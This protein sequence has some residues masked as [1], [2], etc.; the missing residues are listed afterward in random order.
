MCTAFLASLTNELLLKS[1]KLTKLIEGKP[2][3]RAK[4]LDIVP[5]NVLPAPLIDLRKSSV[6]F[7]MKMAALLHEFQHL[8]SNLQTVLRSNAAAGDLLKN[9]LSTLQTTFKTIATELPVLQD[10]Y[11]RLFINYQRFLNIKVEQPHPVLQPVEQEKPNKTYSGDTVQQQSDEFFAVDGFSDSDMSG[12]NDDEDL[13]QKESEDLENVN[14]K[15]AKRYFQP[16][17]KQLKQKIEPLGEAMKERERKVLKAKGIEVVEASDLKGSLRDNDYSSESDGSECSSD[18]KMQRKM[19]K[20][21][22]RYSEVRD[23]LAN[24]EQVNIFMMKPMP[25]VVTEDVL[26]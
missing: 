10:D 21:D 3:D 24:K 19:K 17:L 13:G 16:V 8:D 4:V 14:S 11:Q 6:H 12:T 26:E 22:N 2:S 18:R 20:S 5:G 7:S 9:E 23:F 25:A 15:V 1:A